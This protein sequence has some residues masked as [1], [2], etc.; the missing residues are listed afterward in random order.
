M[1]PDAGGNREMISRLLHP[2]IFVHLSYIRTHNLH[3]S[4]KRISQYYQKPDT[5]QRYPL[6]QKYIEHNE[7]ADC[8][9]RN[10]DME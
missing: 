2:G 3:S 5:Y 10:K 1:I 4:Y 6:S 9:E 8:D 7:G